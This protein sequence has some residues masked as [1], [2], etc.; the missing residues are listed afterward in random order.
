MI[1][2]QLSS[3]LMEQ[4]AF[5]DD[6]GTQQ[7]N[8]QVRFIFS[9]NELESWFSDFGPSK[10]KFYVHFFQLRIEQLMNEKDFAGAFQEALTAAD[11]NLVIMVCQSCDP[12]E[13]FAQDP[14]P[15]N[16]PILLSLIQQLS[17][18]LSS[19]TELKHRYDS[20]V[21]ELGGTQSW[22]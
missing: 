12:V 20:R 19:D 18:D 8:V 2:K 7:R 21:P 4:A 16:Q 22:T 1:Q 11:L 17:V 10:T 13:L 3:V 9:F 6:P 5:A 14:C 15:L